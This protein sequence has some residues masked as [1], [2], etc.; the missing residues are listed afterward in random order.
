MDAPAR[1]LP[2]TSSMRRGSTGMTRPKPTMSMNTVAKT[3]M[4]AKR[5]GCR[6][7]GILLKGAPLL[8]EKAG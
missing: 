1:S 8:A 6:F 4:T 7:M 3:K 2:L 5:P